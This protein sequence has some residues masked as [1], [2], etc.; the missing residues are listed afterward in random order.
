MYKDVY[1]Y[2]I[3]KNGNIQG[4]NSEYEASPISKYIVREERSYPCNS[5]SYSSFF[6]LDNTGKEKNIEWNN[7][8]LISAYITGF[9]SD[10]QLVLEFI[11]ENKDNHKYSLHND[12]RY[13]IPPIIGPRAFKQNLEWNINNPLINIIE[14][15]ELIDTLGFKGFDAVFRLKEQLRKTKKELQSSKLTCDLIC[16]GLSDIEKIE[17][18]EGVLVIEPY[19][20]ECFKSLA[21]I[22]LPSTVE[23]L[24]DFALYN[25]L[26]NNPLREIYCKAVNPPKLSILVFGENRPIPHLR[27]YIPKGTLHL[28]EKTWGGFALYDK[29]MQFIEIEF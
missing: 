21:T 11:D 29:N 24:K 5:Y 2:Q 18:K 28:Y 17:Y 20:L 7:V 12:I 8:K 10:L 16:N 9:A 25:A 26:Y 22:I 27:V 23:E 6:F 15:F 1:Y 14:C 4:I 19:A 3:L 13:N